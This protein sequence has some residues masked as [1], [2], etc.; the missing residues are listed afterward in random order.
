MPRQ[1]WTLTQADASFLI[2][3][4]IDGARAI[5]VAV[6]VVIV[7]GGGSTIGLLRMDAAKLASIGV[8]EG[9]AWTAAFFQRPSIDYGAPSA[10]GGGSYGILN[11]YPGKLVPLPGG[12]PIFI[13]GACIGGIGVSGAT[14]EQDDGLARAA[15]AALVREWGGAE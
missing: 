4:A 7:E 10:P 3:H 14:G 12:Q 6:S 11:A 5:G 1:I 8:A 2:D 9:K 15:V 13:D